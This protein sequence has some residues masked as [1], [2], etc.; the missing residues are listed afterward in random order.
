MT[1]I[2]TL[3]ANHPN[4]FGTTKTTKILGLHRIAMDGTSEIGFGCHSRRSQS[5]LSSWFFE[6]LGSCWFV[7]GMRRH[8]SKRCAPLFELPILKKFAS[9]R[10]DLWENKGFCGGASTLPRTKCGGECLHHGLSLETA[11][12]MPADAIRACGGRR[13]LQCPAA[14]VPVCS[15]PW[16]EKRVSIG[17]RLRLRRC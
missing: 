1:A 12:C 7:F 10:R 5:P 16:R 9:L 13:S 11:R 2:Q 8:R 14:V 3:H 17:L 15:S 6:V 4:A